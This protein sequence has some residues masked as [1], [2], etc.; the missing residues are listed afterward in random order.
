MGGW[1]VTMSDEE[2]AEAVGRL[3]LRCMENE[4]TLRLLAAKHESAPDAS[5]ES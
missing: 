2:F 3:V 4:E 5:T 1:L